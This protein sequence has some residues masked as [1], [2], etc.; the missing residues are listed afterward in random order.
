M[1]S[2][3]MPLPT[4]C[5]VNRA[6]SLTFRDSRNFIST[7][8]QIQHR[9]EWGARGRGSSEVLRCAG[10]H[11]AGG[12]SPRDPAVRPFMYKKC[13]RPE[14]IVSVVSPT[15]TF[16]H[17]NQYQ[18]RLE[19]EPQKHIGSRAWHPCH[20]ASSR[21]AKPLQSEINKG[22]KY[23]DR[24][25]NSFR[26]DKK[27]DDGRPAYSTKKYTTSSP[28]GILNSKLERARDEAGMFTS[29]GIT[30]HDHRFRGEHGHHKKGQW[31]E[32]CV[33]P[34]LQYNSASKKTTRR[35]MKRFRLDR[36]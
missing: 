25:V 4:L 2:M 32:G 30:R 21:A 20:Q 29:S 3:W 8:K 24:L 26:D 28:V 27:L 16:V 33:A 7:T 9:S 36:V 34:P 11:Y 15:P 10:D 35:N 12:T 1:R 23:T 5:D 14:P 13:S 22:E 18:H 6:T 31:G 19:E 17:R